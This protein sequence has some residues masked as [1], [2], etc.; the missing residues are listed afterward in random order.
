MDYVIKENG[1]VFEI[2]SD[3][4]LSP[5][6]LKNSIVQHLHRKEK[7]INLNITEEQ[8]EILNDYASAK[9]IAPGEA[10]TEMARD[11][12]I[13]KEKATKS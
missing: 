2:I 12:S 6:Q 13:L 3:V 4:I 1:R 8:Y 11:I 5:E 7:K 9:G 10:I